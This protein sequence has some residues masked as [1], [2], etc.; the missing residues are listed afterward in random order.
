MRMRAILRNVMFVVRR[1]C[2]CIMCVRVVSFM[3]LLA[4]VPRGIADYV[5]NP[6][7]V[8]V[9]ALRVYCEKRIMTWDA[10]KETHMGKL[11]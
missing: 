10:E 7:H 5:S 2:S 3:Y 8:D 6:G 4:K 9:P 11:G 1:E